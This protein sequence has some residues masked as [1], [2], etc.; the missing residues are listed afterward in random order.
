[1]IDSTTKKIL[2]K[3]VCCVYEIWKEDESF[4]LANSLSEAA[5]IVGLYPNTLSKYLDFNPDTSNS[6]E[7]RPNLNSIRKGGFVAIKKHFIKR[8]RVF[9]GQNN[10][11]LKK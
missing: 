6:K 10:C 3:L 1:V 4:I 7:S 9:T 2:P 11:F 5:N 8:V